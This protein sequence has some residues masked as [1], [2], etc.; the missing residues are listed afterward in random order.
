MKR[1]KVWCLAQSKYPP[2]VSYSYHYHYYIFFLY[3]TER[4]PQKASSPE[5]IYC[6]CRAHPGLFVRGIYFPL[7]GPA[8]SGAPTTM[9][10]EV[11]SEVPTS[12]QAC[13]QETIALNESPQRGPD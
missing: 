10:K 3:P 11:P 4:L 7:Q 5:E 1:L 13:T 9:Q 2:N 12:Q 8:Q 6:S